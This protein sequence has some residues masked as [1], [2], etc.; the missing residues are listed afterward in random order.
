M[1]NWGYV[2]TKKTMNHKRIESIFDRLNISHFN[3][4]LAYN[5][6]VGDDSSCSYYWDLSIDGTHVRGCWLKTSRTWIISHGGNNFMWWVDLLITHTIAMEFNG[7]ITDDADDEKTNPEPEKYNT[8]ESCLNIFTDHVKDPT[9]K[10]WLKQQDQ[11]VFAP[12]EFKI[13]LGPPII[14]S[15]V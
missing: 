2:T 3:G 12:N 5:G 8:Y 9:I 11:E 4:L 1:S 14:I 10:L 7:V 13:D 6:S 15:E